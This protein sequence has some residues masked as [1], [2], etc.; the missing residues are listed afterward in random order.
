M[1][2]SVVIPA[3]NEEKYL[4]RCIKSVL[5]QSDPADE[6]IT[7]DNNSTDTTA[8]IATSFPEVTLLTEKHK[9]TIY[10]RNAGFDA[11]TGDIIIRTD[12]DTKVPKNWIKKIKK[13]FTDDP[14]L[15]ALSG[16][17]RFEDIPKAMQFNNWT[18]VALNASFKQALGHNLMY[19]PNMALRKSIWGKIRKEV[20]MN[21]KIVHE[22]IDLAL[23]IARYGKILFD[24][25]LV[26]VSSFRRWKKLT[27][28]FEYPYRYIRTIQHHTQS[29]KGLRKSRDMMK[30]VLPR[31]RRFLKKL[32]QTTI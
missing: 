27:P 4:A 9:G 31:T 16:A 11:A 19:G 3:Y 25:K 26:V 8:Q 14:T 23:H 28:Y 1:R 17:S 20:C 21:D 6:I 10:A 2:T 32:T 29:M 24:E 22:D 30:T 7:V 15:L 18:V 13:K 5:A 12:A